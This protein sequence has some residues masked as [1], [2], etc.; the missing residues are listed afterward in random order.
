MKNNPGEWPVSYH[1]TKMDF[2]PKILREG[3]IPGFKDV[4][5]F[6]PTHSIYSTPKI[7]IAEGYAQTAEVKGTGKKYK[8]IFQNRLNPKDRKKADTGDH[9]IYYGSRIEDIRLYGLLVK[10]VV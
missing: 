1:G 7:E 3:S 2:V 9:G 6:G 8:F 5:D 10:Q 4:W